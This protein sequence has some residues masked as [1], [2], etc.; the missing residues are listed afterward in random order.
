MRRLDHADE[1]LAEVGKCRR[2]EEDHGRVVA[3]EEDRRGVAVARSDVDDPEV[4][5]SVVCD[6]D[7]LRE[8]LLEAE[9]EGERA[10]AEV[11]DVEDAVGGRRECEQAD[12]LCRQ[13][14]SQL[15][16]ELLDTG[17]IERR[18]QLELDRIAVL[19]DERLRTGIAQDLGRVTNRASLCR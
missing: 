13:R 19:R 12:E 10:A 7:G 17:T 4:A 15:G 1:L 2:L 6:R 16:L 9:S 11:D 3:T 5:I 8:E 18:P 14:E